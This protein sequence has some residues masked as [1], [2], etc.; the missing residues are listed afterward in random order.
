MKGYTILVLKPKSFRDADNAIASLK[1]GQVLLLNFSRLQPQSM[2]RM[3]DYI[4]GSTYA[5]AGQTVEVGNGLFLFT[6]PAINIASR[7]SEKNYSH[8]E[9]NS[10]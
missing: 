10:A 7:S 9:A 3:T 8:I 5:L 4:A 6:P 1:A 2:Q